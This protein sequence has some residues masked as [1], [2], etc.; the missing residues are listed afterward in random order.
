[1]HVV[2]MA[3]ENCALLQPCYS[4][5]ACTQSSS[6][7]F[8][9]C[10]IKDQWPQEVLDGFPFIPTPNSGIDITLFS[11]ILEGLVRGVPTRTTTNMITTMYNTNYKVVLN[12]SQEPMTYNDWGAPQGTNLLIAMLY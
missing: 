6:K 5:L 2:G 12:T 7:T 1:M 8:T 11:M 3:S 10:S 9:L 4:C